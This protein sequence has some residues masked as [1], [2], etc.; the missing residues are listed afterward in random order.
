MHPKK[1]N[2]RGTTDIYPKSSRK[3]NGE[4]RGASRTSGAESSTTPAGQTRVESSLNSRARV[5]SA[6]SCFFSCSRPSGPFT[7]AQKIR[8]PRALV[9]LP[10]SLAGS[11]DFYFCRARTVAADAGL[12]FF[13]WLEVIFEKEGSGSFWFRCLVFVR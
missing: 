2:T 13:V 8:V 9:R 12:F 3:R 7:S 10:C 4:E 1:R 6:A 11:Y 5:V